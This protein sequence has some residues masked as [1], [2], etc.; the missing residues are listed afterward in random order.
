MIEAIPDMEIVALFESDVVRMARWVDIY[1]ADNETI[2]RQQV[3]VTDGAVSVDMG[4]SERRNLDVTFY[5][6]GSLGYGPGA[7]WYDKIIKPYRG[8]E[9]DNGDI[10]ATPLGEFLM[11]NIERPHFPNTISVVGRDFVKKLRLDKFPDTTTFAS[12]LN[13]GTVIQTIAVNGGITKFNFA[14]TAET[15][16]ANITFERDTE[17]WQAMEELAQSIGFEIFFTSFGYL[18]FR[19]NVDPLTAPVSYTFST[20][21]EGNLVNFTKSTTDT[22]MFNDVVVHGSSQDNALVWGRAQNTNINSPTRISEIGRR[23]KFYPSAFVPN[24]TKATEVA[25]SFLAVSALEQFDMNLS[26]I[27][28]PW[29]EAGDAV[30]AIVPDA[31]PGDPTRYLLA[32][33]SIPLGLEAMSGSAKRVTIVG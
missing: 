5:D 30:E 33:F 31:A 32:N 3:P 4:R 28:I 24:N 25:E 8:I 17:R 15:L 27:V 6:D 23:M 7:F 12:G 2:W 11:D 21:E 9:L 14:S 22:F 16:T 13:I 18:T 10:W 1:E 20:G 26:S 19:P 29:L